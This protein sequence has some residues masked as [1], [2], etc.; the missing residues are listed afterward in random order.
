[1][2][3]IDHTPSSVFPHTLLSFLLLDMLTSVLL[4][5]LVASFAA[6]APSPDLSFSVTNNGNGS[7]PTSF[8]SAAWQ[9]GWS[10]TN[11]SLSTINWEKYSILAWAFAVTTSDPSVLSLEDSGPSYIPAFVQQAHDH[12][13]LAILTVG[14]WTGSTYFSPAVTSQNR[15]TFVKA[16]LGMVS[17]YG[18]DGV[19]FDWE[20]PAATGIGCNQMSPSD[21][22]NFLAFLQDLRK[23]PAGQNLYL[24]AAVSPTP[25]V[26][27]DG[28]PMTDVSDFA[29]VLNHI[30]VMNY[31]INGQWT[32]DTG[33]GP[34]APL[35]DSCSK[36]QIGS[37]IKAV[38]AWTAAGIPSNQI[39]LGVPA[40]GHSYNVTTANSVDSSGNVADHP[41]FTKAPLTSSVDQ[42]GTPEPAV[43]VITFASM[44]SE[45]ILNSDGT[46][47]NGVKYRF[48]SC[49]QTPFAYDQTRQLMISYDDPTSFT[50]KGKFIADNDLLGF[51]M[52][53][54]TGDYKDL[55]V[56]AITTGAGVTDDC[57]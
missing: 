31:D 54:I 12:N 51:S 23:D 55:L 53:D 22:A 10:T 37:A 1:M 21:T 50:A 35:D 19:D 7:Q 49:S 15:S 34:N 45:G 46:A 9:P 2:F 18:F 16:V 17:K 40:Y 25:F 44:I 28:K 52:W 8:I 38:K 41:S 57:N 11:T 29:A 30:T 13:T 26:G 47:A 20:Y 48:D 56:D 36:V 27:S 43:D 4:S 39:L 33:V 32:T 6:A 24:S 3:T 14:G 42:C 5:A